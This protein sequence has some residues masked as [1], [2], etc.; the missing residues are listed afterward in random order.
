MK[1]LWSR[2]AIEDLTA[3]RSYISEHSPKAAEGV[4]RRILQAVSFLA[5]HPQ[6]GVPTHR[7]DVRKLI[8]KQSPYIIPYR[9]VDGEIEIL[10]VFDGRQLAPRTDMTGRQD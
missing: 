6:L 8:V 5:D 3:I 9:I 1:I 4:A 10:E 2:I 7:T